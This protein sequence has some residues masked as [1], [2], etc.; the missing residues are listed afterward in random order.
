MFRLTT[1]HGH[2]SESD[3]VAAIVDASRTVLAAGHPGR[4]ELR[5]IGPGHCWT[6]ATVYV[7]EE[8]EL[9]PTQADDIAENIRYE[10]H[11]QLDT[12]DTVPP[13]AEWA[14]DTQHAH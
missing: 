1:N 12:G 13:P 11:R 6:G 14:D 9:H 7:P 10:L 2:T 8:S 5:I 3:T 4:T